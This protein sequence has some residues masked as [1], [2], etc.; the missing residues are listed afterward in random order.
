MSSRCEARRMAR[1]RKLHE[2]SGGRVRGRSSWRA[3]QSGGAAGGGA[4]VCVEGET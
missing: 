4:R 1:R 3:A 2:D